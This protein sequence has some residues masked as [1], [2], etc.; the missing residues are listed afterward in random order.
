MFSDEPISRAEEDELSIFASAR[1]MVELIES[2]TS[3][4]SISIQGEWGSGKTTLMRLVESALAE[5]PG[6]RTIH[7]DSWEYSLGASTTKLAE[8]ITMSIISEI[9]KAANSDRNLAAIAREAQ[10]FLAKGAALVVSVQGGDGATIH[11]LL[12]NET[13]VT[14]RLREAVASLTNDKGASRFI[15]FVDDLDR[16]EPAVA[17][18][19]LEMLRNVLFVPN[20]CFI[21]AI[22]FD[23]VALGL[24][25]RYSG[26]GYAEEHVRRD[27]FDKLFQFSYFVAPNPASARRMLRKGLHSMGY[28][29]EHESGDYEDLT[30]DTIL[31]LVRNNPRR[32]KRVLN[33]IHYRQY[34]DKFSGGYVEHGSVQLRSANA[35][36]ATMTLVYPE[37]VRALM[38]DP[39]FGAPSQV[40]WRALAEVARPVPDRAVSWSEEWAELIRF[41]DHGY[42]AD[43]IVG[44]LT[45]IRQLVGS[46][47][48]LNFR[49]L[50]GVSQFASPSI[51]EVGVGEGDFAS[52]VT[53]PVRYGRRLL[54]RVAIK[55]RARVLHLACQDGAVT[56]EMLDRY[57]AAT[58]HA[59]EMQQ[60][61]FNAAKVTLH[62]DLQ[63]GGRC[64]LSLQSIEDV[65]FYHR[66]DTVFSVTAIHWLGRGAY[67]KSYDALKPG[68]SLNVEQSM[69]GTYSHM[70][71]VL[72]RAALELGVD[73]SRHVDPFYMPARDELES[74][75]TQVGFDD[76]SVVVEADDVED[77]DAL[78]VDY[79]QSNAKAYLDTINT[80]SLRVRILERFLELCRSEATPGTAE[81]GWITAIKARP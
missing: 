6:V 42:L 30:L 78:Y 16:V 34:L 40:H 38:L 61:L 26:G 63:P 72:F 79:A 49:V 22:D 9:T 68:G 4:L 45:A 11:D 7:V 66:F 36:L 47:R 5:R 46:D 24:Q 27:Y 59:V 65:A 76:V 25:Q 56:R 44:G 20:L 64:T 17:I 50:L 62:D 33:S 60:A 23:V 52:I 54:D 1:A 69:A 48:K 8:Q 80:S 55:E 37:F 19:T 53:T 77:L 41:A 28:F 18:E 51:G 67:A 57:P 81:V 21:M 10:N 35:I 12:Q 58:V 3:P 13:D 31:A 15:I 74:W 29:S 14:R 43:P 39:D 71:D 75:L 2:T 32:I 70:R 73:L